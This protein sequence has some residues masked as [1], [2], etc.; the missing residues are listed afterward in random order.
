MRELGD[1]DA[2]GAQQARATNW[3]ARRLVWTLV[4]ILLSFALV[5]AACGDDDSE[6]AQP[7]PVDDSPSAGETAEGEAEAPTAEG[8]AEAPTAAADSDD[9]AGDDA[10]GDDAAAEDQPV[11]GVLQFVFWDNSPAAAEGWRALAD[12]FEEAHP[13]ITVE[14]LPIQGDGWG[15]YLAATATAI[16]GGERPDTMYVATEGIEFLVEN[17]MLMPI[18]GLIE[19]DRDE[20]SDF[21]DDVTPAMIDAFNVNGNQ[22]LLP[23]SWNNMLI[24]YNTA[25]LAEAGLDEPSSDWT[26]DDFLAYA[27]SL[28]SDD[29]G[30]GVNDRFGFAW[31]NGVLFASV[32]P[33]I[34][35]NGGVLINEDGTANLTSPEVVEAVD[36]MRDLIYEHEVATT[37]IG[38]GDLYTR[39]KSGDLAMFGAGRWP[40]LNFVPEEFTDFNI[41]LWPTNGGNELVTEFGIDGFP[42]FAEAQNVD[43][44]WEWL[45]FMTSV[46]VQNRF[47]GTK[48]SPVGNIPVRRS[49]S[50]GLGQ[51]G[52]D[53][54]EAFY[55]SLE[56]QALPVPA[57]PEYSQVDS[58]LT[59]YTG[60]VFADEF[61]AEEAMDAAQDEWETILGG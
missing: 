17:E 13:D 14:L 19:R 20:M 1:H 45:K 50:A 5:A 24:Y 25:R 30:D 6:T 55:E 23:Y 22:Y 47:I 46:E 60:L 48:D 35:S 21:L 10:A 34:Y 44:A 43:A 39:F 40:M 56:G 61:T 12:D 27:Q 16:A 32:V 7:A 58:A 9:I 53:N 28:S 38:Y 2:T 33:W 37:P 52:P 51:F 42:I 31:D 15:G 57:P 4:A 3:K 18:D 49:V 41:Q 54:W 36:F 29:D 8:E 26:W 11:S 59:R